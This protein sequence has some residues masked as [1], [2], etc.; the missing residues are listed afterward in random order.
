M[1]CSQASKCC[2]NTFHSQ[3]LLGSS[4]EENGIGK[5]FKSNSCEFASRIFIISKKESIN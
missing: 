3:E 4:I 2:R 1:E 5:G